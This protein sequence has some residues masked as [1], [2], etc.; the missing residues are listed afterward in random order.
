MKVSPMGR[1]AMRILSDAPLG[2]CAALEST[3]LPGLIEVVPAEESVLL[4]FSRAISP[5]DHKYLSALSPEHVTAPA[6]ARVTIDAIY[7]DAIYNGTDLA[8]F[9]QMCKMS[10]TSVIAHHLAADYQV[11][12][13]GFAPGF[14][15]LV[16]LDPALHKPRRATPRTL[17]PAGS[18][19]VAGHYSAVYPRAS[20][21]GWHLLG[22]T[23]AP[24]FDPTQWP[25]STLTPGTRVNFRSVREQTRV[26]EPVVDRTPDPRVTS[27]AIEILSAGP[28]TLIQDLGRHG[29]SRYAVGSSGA[30]DTSAHQLAQRLV[31][32]HESAAGF[33]CVGSGLRLLAH[34]AMTVAVT[35]A[36]GDLWIESARGERAISANGPQSVQA[37]EILHLGPVRYGLRRWL[38]VRGGIDVPETLGS[39]SYDML[40]HLG[41]RPVA[42]HDHYAIGSVTAHEPLVDYA[43]G[44]HGPTRDVAV[45]IGPDNVLDVAQWENFLCTD[46]T[47]STNSDRVGVRLTGTPL[48]VPSDVMNRPSAGMVRGAMQLP[49]D[50]QPVVLGPDHP[51]TGGYPVIAVLADPDLPAQWVPGGTI[52]FHLS[53]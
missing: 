24:L 46:F 16:G 53:R 22:T 18:I 47:V 3:P 10:T 8:E 51:V 49:P 30:W 43:P 38:A 1:F 19:A 25:P 33:E 4:R 14:A 20:P 28:L 7:I 2:L 45:V 17:V 31:G 26:T 15:Y 37:G 41:P 50:G 29:L 44:T 35:G 9:A 6:D 48:H 40:S 27:G 34:R 36:P 21:G 52:R 13:C 11:S 12:F 5:D 42:A 23:Q 32:N 39:C